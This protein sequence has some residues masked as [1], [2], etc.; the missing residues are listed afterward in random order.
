MLSSGL[1]FGVVIGF[2][3]SVATIIIV[4]L[5]TGKLKP[6]SG[7]GGSDSGSDDGD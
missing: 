3:L 1:I 5:A 6:G 2:I 7:G 4:G